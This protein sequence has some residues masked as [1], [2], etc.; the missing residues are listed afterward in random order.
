MPSG[1]SVSDEFARPKHQR[2]T[3]PGKIEAKV[4]AGLLSLP[5][6]TCLPGAKGV[7]VR[8]T[9]RITLFQ[10]GLHRRLRLWENMSLP[11]QTVANSLTA[12]ETRLKFCSLVQERPFAD[13][14]TLEHPDLFLWLEPATRPSCDMRQRFIRKMSPTSI[15]IAVFSHGRLLTSSLRTGTA[16]T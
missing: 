8:N 11:T 10:I 13:L 3:L 15:T 9:H 4:F 6:H 1:A 14:W 12:E 16:T 5:R 2:V 7:V